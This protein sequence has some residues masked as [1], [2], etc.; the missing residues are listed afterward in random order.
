MKSK[1][2]DGSSV[3]KLIDF[4]AARELSDENGFKSLYGTPEYLCPD[5]YKRAIL[6]INADQTF[7]A[8]VDLW[9]IGAT[10]YHVATGRLPFSPF[11]G[12]RDAKTMH[13]ITSQ[14][15]NLKF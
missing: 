8:T 1:N 14:K 4:G 11:K 2:S 15:V 12:R 5:M 6:G 13:Y 3:Y 10:L 9:S 7:R